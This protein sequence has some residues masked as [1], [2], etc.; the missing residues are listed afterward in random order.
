MVH[1][2]VEGEPHSFSDIEGASLR[3]L[4]SVKRLVDTEG[5][6]LGSRKPLPKERG[7]RGQCV[8]TRIKGDDVPAP[9][10]TEITLL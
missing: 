4:D 2:S 10:G 3:Q 5:I 9:S 7:D 6:H 1:G 8:T